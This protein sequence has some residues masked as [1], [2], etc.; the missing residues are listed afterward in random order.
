M[1]LPR[2]DSTWHGFALIASAILLLGA[3]L[4]TQLNST[5]DPYDDVAQAFR[6]QLALL[7][8]GNYDRVWQLTAENCRGNMD[9]AR[10]SMR[11]SS[12]YL[13]DSGYTW[14]EAFSVRD[15]FINASGSQAIILLDTKV[16]GPTFGLFTKVDGTWLIDCS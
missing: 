1:S 2:L 7:D 15:V 14:S 4:Y 3:Y 8:E 11:M 12:K 13:R 6:Y 10:V 9:A 16:A 5:D